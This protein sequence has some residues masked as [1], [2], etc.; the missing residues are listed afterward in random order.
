MNYLNTDEEIKRGFGKPFYKNG[1]P[2]TYEQ[3]DKEWNIKGNY[4]I[5]TILG[6]LGCLFYFIVSY[7]AKGA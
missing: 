5:L 7:I 3:K 4:I 2:K 6:L 1:E